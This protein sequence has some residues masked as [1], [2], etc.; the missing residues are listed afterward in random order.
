VPGGVIP[1]GVVSVGVLPGGV[2]TVGVLPPA[3]VDDCVDTVL[4]GGALPRSCL[5]F[6]PLNLCLCP[7]GG[8]GLRAVGLESPNAVIRSALLS[9]EDR[10]DEDFAPASETTRDDSYR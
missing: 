3:P 8:L 5:A 9:D 1:G 10:G 6:D 7:L 2:V 4:A